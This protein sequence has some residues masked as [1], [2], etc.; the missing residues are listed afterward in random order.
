MQI[1][2][3]DSRYLQKKKTQRIIN[4]TEDNNAAYETLREKHKRVCCSETET[5]PTS[6]H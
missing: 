5:Q 1:K 2:I 4:I 6:Y 3:A